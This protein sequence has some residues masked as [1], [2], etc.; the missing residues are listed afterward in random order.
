MVVADAVSGH[1]VSAIVV[2][3]AVVVVFVGGVVTGVVFGV[4]VDVVTVVD[5][6]VVL[7]DIVGSGPMQSA[8]MNVETTLVLTTWL[9]MS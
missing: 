7:N 3:V 5:F 6:V 4:I 1:V 8:P 9:L 2:V